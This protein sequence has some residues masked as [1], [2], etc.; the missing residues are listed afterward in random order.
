M[1]QR[2]RQQ[3]GSALIVAMLLLMGLAFVGGALIILTSSDLKNAG[4]DRRGTQASFAAEG[5]IAEAMHRLS[6]APGSTVTVNG[7][8]FD[9][10]IEDTS[11]PL[12]P[13]W[14]ARIYAPGTTPVSAGSL[15]YFKTVQPT[16]SA[17]DYS[18]TSEYLSITHKWR[19]RNANNVREANEMVLYD[20]KKFP[21]ENFDTG[22][23]IEVIDVQGHHADSQRRLMVECTRFPFTANTMA[24]LSSDRGIDVRG[25]VSICGHDHRADTPVGT[26]LQ[27]NPP[28]SPNYDQTSG[29][30]PAI[31]TTGDDVA[32][33]GS[34]DLLGDPVATDTSSTNPFYTLAQCLGVTQ[35]VI[36]Q[37]LHQADNTSVTNPLNGITY[38]Q[39]NGAIHNVDGQGLL[40]VTGDLSISGNFTYKGL[41]YVEGD[42]S[43]TGTPWILGGV[44][45]RG[46]SDYAFSGGSP[47]ILYSS[48]MIRLAIQ[49]AFQYVVLSW[50]EQ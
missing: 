19:D 27:T 48:A 9:P 45:V 5:G 50:K 39:G 29:H 32:R 13:N 21:P 34:T 2:G 6:A 35:D 11:S 14:E 49:S 31:T 1:M 47:A 36:D 25:N 20:P 15:H 40:Y 43:I 33:R 3:Q 17:L 42:L 8:T 10:S 23:P 28:C 37:V 41:I 46:H 7:S 38:I 24:A 44:M 26:D 12:D 30:L 22:S 18:R 4:S 16:A